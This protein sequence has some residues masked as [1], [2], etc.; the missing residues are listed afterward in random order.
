MTPVWIAAAKRTAV[1]PRAGSLARVEVFEL[2]A[3]VIKKLLEDFEFEADWRMEVIFGNAL[4][5]GG[6]PARV[7]ALAADL[8][9]HVPAL[10]IDSQCCS[11]LDAIA[12]GASRI[13]SGAAD[14]VIAGGLE[15]YSRSPL[16]LRRPRE[17]GEQPQAYQRPPFTPWPGRDPDLAASAAALAEALEISRSAQEE[18]AIASHAK[19]I[20]ADLKAEIVA[21]DGL[22]RDSFSRALT[23]ELCMRLP[24]IAGAA[25]Y[26]LTAATTAVEADAAAAVLLVNSDVMPR[27]PHPFRPVKLVDS[28]SRGFDPERPALAP[29]EAARQLLERNAIAAAD[30][31]V[32][33]I[34]EAF[35]VQAMAFT[36][37]LGISQ[38]CVNRSGGSLARGHPIGASGAILAVRLFHEL[39]TE[40]SGARGL[41]AI[42]AAGG[43][44]SAMLLQ[45]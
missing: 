18:F 8:A 2:G 5:G 25:P 7:A 26:A 20:A 6:N 40:A 17:P 36:A 27:L 21:V 9:E 37:S 12:M 35:A 4:Y 38:V 11:G 14:V 22:A 19:A 31:S 23:A 10:T 24:A 29:I 13:A 34:M 30:I 45:V 41:A 43:L 28:H 44:G 33:E 15:S 1:A 39:Q 16:R 3:A 32:T 42:A